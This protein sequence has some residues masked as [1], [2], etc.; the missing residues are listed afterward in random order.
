MN[1][2]I[3]D[4]DHTL[5]DIDSDY[6]WNQ[7]IS[8]LGYQDFETQNAINDNFYLDYLNGKLNMDD[9]LSFNLKFFSEHSLEKIDK[10]LKEFVTKKIQPQIRSKAMTIVNNH[11]K[12]GHTILI[13]TATNQIVTTPIAKFLE[14]DNLLATEVE[15]K[16]GKYTGR[17]KG[18]PSFADGKVT[19]LQD[20]L[21]PH[22]KSIAD[23]VTYFYSDSFNDRFLL[24][25]VTYPTAVNPDSKLKAHANKKNWPIVDWRNSLN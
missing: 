23:C 21:Q 2:A 12:L 7:Y 4:L 9:Y 24:D 3:F 13:I 14:I 5:I 19:R 10:L 17:G 18:I 16:N 8:E 20:W 22:N 11:R 25:L 15:I 6:C 1:L